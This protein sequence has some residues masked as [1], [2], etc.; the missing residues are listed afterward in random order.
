[1]KE[2]TDEDEER[3][4]WV[5][6]K[7]QGLFEVEGK[8][9]M[10]LPSS[11]SGLWRKAKEYLELPENNNGLITPVAAPENW[12]KDPWYH[13]K[14]KLDHL[15]YWKHPEPGITFSYKDWKTGSNSNRAIVDIVRERPEWNRDG[16]DKKPVVPDFKP[17]NIKLQD[18]FREQGLQVIVHIDGIELTPDN[19]VYHAGSWQ[20][21]GQLN[22]HVVAVTVF[23]YDVHNV[24]E[25]K[26]SFRQETPIPEW[27]YRYAEERFTPGC[28]RNPGIRDYRPL[29][30][31]GKNSDMEITAISEIL[32]IKARNLLHDWHWNRTWQK[33]ES[34][35]TPQGRLITFANVMEH[36]INHFKLIN[37]LIPGHY[38]AVKL[39]LVDPHY[40]VCSTRNVPPQ[41]HNWWAREVTTKVFNKSNALPQELID[42]II[43]ETRDW[44][45][46]MQEATQHR[47]EMIK[48]HRWNDYVRIGSMPMFHFD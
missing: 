22:E 15:I 2:K 31:Y 7:L 27:F 37:P 33:K 9:D 35:A 42:E 10:E 48:E 29:H 3:L 1:V 5:Q 43:K 17:Y 25:P 47:L 4:R 24:T 14:R 21:P 19:P 41:Q 46:S 34:L 32:G 28:R 38:R 40:R 16:Q 13:I 45:M 23:P 18:T 44:P 12:T 6:G 26:I 30:R 36:R 8:E 11:N 39:Y 20:L